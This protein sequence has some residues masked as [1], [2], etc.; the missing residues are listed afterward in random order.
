MKNGIYGT[1]ML[2]GAFGEEIKMKNW[3]ILFTAPGVAQ[4]VE[5]DMP[6][7]GDDEVIVRILRTTISAGTERALLTGD[8]N[9]S[10]TAAGSVTFPRKSGYSAAGV[11]TEIGRKVTT[12]AVGDRVACSWSSH[13]QYCKLKETRVYRLDDAISDAEAA[14]IHIG[15]FPAAAIRK[16][17]LEFGESAIVMG[18]G[19][20]GMITVELLRVA[21][22][23]PIIAVD[24]VP[25]KRALALSLGADYALDPFMEGF[26]EKVKELTN[27]GAQ[28]GIE[29]TGRGSGLDMILDC[30]ARFGRVALLGCTRNSDFSIDYYRK[31]HGPGITLVG[32][33]TLAR[34][35][36]ESSSGWWTERDDAFALLKLLLLKRLDFARLV[37]EVHSPAEATEIYDRL[38]KHAAFPIV[39]FDWTRFE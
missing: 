1:G 32:A 6:V 9:I 38:A 4:L 10:S 8:P 14:L 37:E 5:G 2:Y 30:M 33:H 31:V 18:M 25:E 21:G 17:R 27:G 22:A 11:V 19:V 24:P 23:A 28:V 15:T 29:I 34:P 13:A 20:L 16:C 7:C 12:V 39:Q 36:V 3:K 26:A 35:K